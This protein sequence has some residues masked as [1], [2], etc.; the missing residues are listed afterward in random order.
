MKLKLCV[1]Q[2]FYFLDGDFAY[3]WGGTMFKTIDI[4]KKKTYD[5]L[6]VTY[7]LQ[8]CYKIGILRFLISFSLLRIKVAIIAN[9]YCI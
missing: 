4:S 1:R 7:M 6:S 3:Y 2:N 9:N 5:L 8:P